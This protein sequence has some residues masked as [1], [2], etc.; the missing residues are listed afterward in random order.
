M[1]PA[2]RILIIDDELNLRRSLAIG[3]KLEG[4]EADAVGTAEA[5]LQSLG[6]K[7]FDLVLIDLMMP[8]VHGLELAR[9]VR[10]MH[11]NVRIVLT[12]AYHLSE[13]QM[14][15]AD[16]GAIG[17]V[18]KPYNIDDLAKFLRAKLSGAVAVA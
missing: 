1:V 11:P 9:R 10:T 4:F 13:R 14:A 6:E 7:P 16:C 8:G 15:Q 3:L 18:P 17:F 2:P 12:S 5:A